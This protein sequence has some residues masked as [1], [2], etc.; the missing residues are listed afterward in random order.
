M[1]WYKE[2]FLQSVRYSVGKREKSLTGSHS[3]LTH[4]QGAGMWPRPQSWFLGRLIMLMPWTR[5]ES[6]GRCL[7]LASVS[8]VSISALVLAWKASCTTLPG[9]RS[10]VF[11]KLSQ[12]KSDLICICIC[13]T[14]I[15]LPLSRCVIFP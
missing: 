6:T 9:K 13:I 4:H 12:S 11:T 10:H 7:D 1:R 8:W 5:L 15:P 2:Q 14:T 3:F